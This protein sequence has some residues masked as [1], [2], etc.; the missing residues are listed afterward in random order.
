MAWISVK[1]RLPEEWQH[2]LVWGRTVSGPS[3]GK[4]KDAVLIGYYWKSE[5]E[6]IWSSADSDGWALAVTHWQPLPEGPGGVAEAV[7]SVKKV[8]AEGEPVIDVLYDWGEGR[9]DREPVLQPD[10]PRH[11]RDQHP[12]FLSG[13]G[14]S[15][16]PSNKDPIE[17]F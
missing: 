13:D 2:V 11:G 17:E 9:L 12:E 3:F 8:L 10:K 16:E 7:A 6:Q 5:E 14:Q 1:E 15:A 4:G